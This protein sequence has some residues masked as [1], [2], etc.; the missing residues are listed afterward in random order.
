LVAALTPATPAPTITIFFAIFNNLIYYIFFK[1]PNLNKK[2][3]H[4]LGAPQLH[5][6]NPWESTGYESA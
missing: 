2:V 5:N 6:F 3:T 1:F 4:F